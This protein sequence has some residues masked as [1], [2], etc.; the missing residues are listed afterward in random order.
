MILYFITGMRE[1]DGLCLKSEYKINYTR[2]IGLIL[3]CKLWCWATAAN[4]SPACVI[5]KVPYVE[6]SYWPT[7]TTSTVAIQ[8]KVLAI[9]C[10]GL[11]YL[12]IWKELLQECCNRLSQCLIQQSPS[13]SGF[14]SVVQ[15]FA[16][17]PWSEKQ[18]SPEFL[19]SWHFIL[20]FAILFPLET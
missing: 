16:Q 2:Q 9:K 3:E 20:P 7:G 4:T 15:V 13:S 12:C 14:C 8:W 11:F 10:G 6:G 19:H 18:R 1:Q 17:L 5:I